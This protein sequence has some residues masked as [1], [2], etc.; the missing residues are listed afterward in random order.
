MIGK[1]WVAYNKDK[2]ILLKPNPAMYLDNFG[3]FETRLFDYDGKLY[4]SVS[5]ECIIPKDDWTEILGSEFHRV[6]EALD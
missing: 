5:S 6:M 2:K 4:C 1:E 3:H